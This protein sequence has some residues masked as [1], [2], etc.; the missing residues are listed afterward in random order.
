[1]DSGEILRFYDKNPDDFDNVL[2]LSNTAP[3]R[4]NQK[5][6]YPVADKE[7]LETIFNEGLKPDYSEDGVVFLWDGP[8]F[9]AD[10]LGY[11]HDNPC[12]LGITIPEY[13]VEID[14]KHFH[15]EANYGHAFKCKKKIKRNRLKLLEIW[16]E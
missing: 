11:R 6:F 14:D 7:K 9:V 12:L 1:L 2:V 8:L 3:T 5:L 4:A 15:F 10:V 16:R 13:C